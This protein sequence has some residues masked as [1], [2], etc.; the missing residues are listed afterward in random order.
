MKSEEAY[1]IQLDNFEG[2][3]E[4]LLYLVQKNEIDI[5]DVRL[6]AVTDQFLEEL[7]NPDLD[8]GAEF[9]G[10][11]AS[12][13]WLKSKMLLPKHQQASQEDEDG[14]DPHF[15]VIHQL[16]DYCHFKEAGHALVTL[17][18]EQTAYFPRGVSGNIEVKKP[19]GIEHLALEDLA[20]LFQDVLSKCEEE[21][22]H[23]QEET[24]RVSDKIRFLKKILHEGASFSFEQL[25][26]LNKCKEELIV[27]FLAVL[28]LMK[29]GIAAVFQE[30][31]TKKILFGPKELD[32]R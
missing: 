3:L 13:L 24:F 20:S 7:Q 29:L 32:R 5:H 12:L 2:P 17:E 19:L 6:H 8:L 9:V 23:V 14:P 10:T 28:E 1:S 4:F 26:P 11:V 18:K 15:D 16:I 25:F 31:Q 27:T 21:R 30:Q 22:G